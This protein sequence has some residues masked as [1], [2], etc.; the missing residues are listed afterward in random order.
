[1]IGGVQEKIAAASRDGATVFLLPKRNCV[2]VG[3]VPPGLR[4]VP[5]DTLSGAIQSLSALTKPETADSV[6]GCQ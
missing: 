6:V 4:L 5:V 3:A 1:A 2:D